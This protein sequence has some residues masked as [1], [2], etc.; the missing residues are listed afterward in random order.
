MLVFK[1]ETI[2]YF[3]YISHFEKKE[4][5]FKKNTKVLLHLL[6][7]VV[8][9]P[10]PDPFETNSV[11]SWWHSDV[12]T[13]HNITLSANVLVPGTLTKKYWYHVF[14]HG[15][16]DLWPMTLTIELIR[17][18]IKV[19]P[20]TKFC[21]DMSNG[22]A[23][24]VPTNRHT[25]RHTHPEGTVFITSTADAAGNNRTCLWTIASKK[26]FAEQ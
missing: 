13:S 14:W 25:H 21:D 1:F 26:N 7:A 4:K 12:M 22:S 20:C 2:S 15:D 5:H 3:S 11:T 23:V 17:H 10:P 24:R 18:I 6:R 8:D 9:H 19:N 16:L